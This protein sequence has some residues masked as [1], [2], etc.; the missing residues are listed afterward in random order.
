MYKR[1][2]SRT[3][4]LHDVSLATLVLHGDKDTLIDSSGGRRTAEAIPGARFVL[5]EGLGH[6][7][8]PP[9]WDPVSYTHLDVYKR[10][11]GDGAAL[12]RRCRLRF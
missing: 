8:P 4:A 11:G 3:A 10:Q 1:Q 2:G 6:D 7:Y 12:E 9:Y 5:I